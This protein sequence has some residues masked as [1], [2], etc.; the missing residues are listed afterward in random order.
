MNNCQRIV[1]GFSPCKELIW[2]ENSAHLPHIEE[3]KKLNDFLINYVSQYM[4][5]SRFL[6]CSALQEVYR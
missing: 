1:R 2:F 3:N 5:K 6:K 4:L